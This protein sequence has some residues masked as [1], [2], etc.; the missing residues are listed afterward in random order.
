MTESSAT[1]MPPPVVG[2][3]EEAKC[4]NSYPS[5]LIA[6]LGLMIASSII[7]IG[8]AVRKIKSL[9]EEPASVIEIAEKSPQKAATDFASNQS[10]LK[11]KMQ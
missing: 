8:F 2:Q 6:V 9:K 7:P 4:E 5:G 11:L 3:K 1:V 10:Q